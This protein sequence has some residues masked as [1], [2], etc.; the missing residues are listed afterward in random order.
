ADGKLYAV[1]RRNGTFVLAAKPKF[2]QLAH[3][4][5]GEGD[6]DFNASPSVSGDKILI[7]S[8]SFLYCLSKSAKK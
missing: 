6:G 5:L 2:E 1:S 8:D 3:N 4:D 7:R